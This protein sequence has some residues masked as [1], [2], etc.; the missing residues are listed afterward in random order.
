MSE[1]G[2]TP[3]APRPWDPA[4]TQPKHDPDSL[5]PE[6][7][8]PL[9]PPDAEVVESDAVDEDGGDLLPERRR[10]AGAPAVAVPRGHSPFAP[11]FQF[12]TGALVA[13]GVAALVGIAVLVI[14][15][16]TATPGP[17]WSPWKPS[18]NGVGGATEIATHIAPGYRDSGAQLVKVEA[19]D[20][21]FKGI[22]LTVALRKAPDQGGDIQV[23]DDKGVLYQMCGLGPNCSIDHGKPSIA[24][25]FLLKREALELALYSFRYLDIKQVVVLIPPR[26][27]RVQT[28]ALY[29]RRGDVQAELQRPL[30]ASLLPR[31]PSVGTAP[32]AP[33]APLVKQA[34]DES[35]LFTLM[36]SSF[37]D[38]GFLVLDPYTPAADDKLQKQLRQQAATAAATSGG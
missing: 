33:D 4:G 24:R 2:E 13:V 18:Q 37:N 32:V 22:P 7:R 20:M 10:G 12:L 36:G 5:L 19:N 16:S 30:T 15:P 23:H 35:Y 14:G 3:Q 28:V 27:G 26:P 31:A 9:L 21:R 11:R 25:T 1:H 6:R 17:A 34:T 8:E 38:K 29:F